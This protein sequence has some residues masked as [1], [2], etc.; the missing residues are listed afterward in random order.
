M[1]L[2]KEEAQIKQMTEEAEEKRRA[3]NHLAE[4]KRK[5]QYRAQKN[6]NSEVYDA[7]MKHLELLKNLAEK[8]REIAEKDVAIAR[9]NT[10][11]AQKEA[12]FTQKFAQAQHFII[13]LTAKLENLEKKDVGGAGAKKR[14]GVKARVGLNIMNRLGEPFEEV[15]VHGRKGQLESDE[16]AGFYEESNLDEEDILTEFGENGPVPAKKR[17]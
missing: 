17:K 1:K 10:V 12:I 4:K 2:E 13:Q 14:L 8:D 16:N 9:L 6:N 3:E 5:E 11:I 15:G 7:K